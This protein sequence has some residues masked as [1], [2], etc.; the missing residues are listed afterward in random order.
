MFCGFSY[1]AMIIWKPYRLTGIRGEIRNDN[2]EYCCVGEN[3]GEN[4]NV[5]RNE[6]ITFENPRM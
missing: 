4:E 6:M 2:R 3:G 5:A 1:T